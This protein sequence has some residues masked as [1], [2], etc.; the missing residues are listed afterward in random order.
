MSSTTAAAWRVAIAWIALSAVVCLSARAQ[1]ADTL[2][3][4]LREA[5][6]AQRWQKALSAALSIVALDPE[7]PTAHYNAGCVLALMGESEAAA[8]ALAHAAELGFSAAWTF[9]TDPDLESVRGHPGYAAALK[10]VEENHARE[11]VAF[12]QKTDASEPLIYPPPVAE[13]AAG[14]PRPVIV[15]LHGRGGRAEKMARLFRPSAAK[16]GAVLVVPEAFEPYGDGFQWGKVDDG[17]YRVEHAIEFAAER[18]PIDRRRVIVAGFSQGAYLSLASVA[19]DPRRFAGAVAIGACDVQGLELAP[20]PLEDPPPV[21]IGIGSEDP[22][23]D[24]CRPVV[25]LYESFGFEVKFRVYRGYGH[26][27]PQNYVW[28]IDR[29]LRFVLRGVAAG[30]RNRARPPKPI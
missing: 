2:Q 14:E 30:R 19:R 25:K 23:Y 29:A 17:V 7:D 5:I 12:K 26:V 20:E 4:R 3:R 9:R 1:D 21:Y 13:G 15:L 10:R 18:H 22:G 8:E 16:I 27:F 11:F 28:E 24:G 6:E